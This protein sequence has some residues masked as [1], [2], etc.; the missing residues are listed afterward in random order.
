MVIVQDTGIVRAKNKIEKQKIIIYHH[1]HHSYYTVGIVIIYSVRACVRAWLI[2][3]AAAVRAHSRAREVPVGFARLRGGLPAVRALAVTGLP[4]DDSRRAGL[5]VLRPWSEQQ[6]KK[7]K[8]EQQANNN[9]E[10]A[11]GASSDC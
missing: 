2:R 3:T 5:V 6:Y 10:R 7:N 1:P 4:G 11:R 8:I 9:K